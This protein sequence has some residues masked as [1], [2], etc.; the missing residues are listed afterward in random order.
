MIKRIWLW[1]NRLMDRIDL[2]VR[3]YPNTPRILTTKEIKVLKRLDI[4]ERL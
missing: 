1:F 2:E 3:S 4:L